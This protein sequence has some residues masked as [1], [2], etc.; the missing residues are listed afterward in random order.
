MQTYEKLVQ[1]NSTNVEKFVM[2]LHRIQL[3]Y[4]AIVDRYFFFLCFVIFYFDFVL[5]NGTKELSFSFLR[6]N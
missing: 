3:N 1:L 4:S 6:L 5:F 2:C